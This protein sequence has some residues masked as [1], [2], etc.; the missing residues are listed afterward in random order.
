MGIIQSDTQPYLELVLCPRFLV[1]VGV[2]LAS[3]RAV[4]AL[5]L[6]PVRGAGNAEH[7]VIIARGVHREVGS[8]GGAARGGGGAALGHR[9]AVEGRAGAGAFVALGGGQGWR[10]EEERERER[11]QEG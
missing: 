4:G 7:L 2:E 5:H 1:D 9:L 10:E 3:Q 6:L 8:T 11:Q